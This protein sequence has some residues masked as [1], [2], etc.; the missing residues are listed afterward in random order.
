MKKSISALGAVS[1]AAILVVAMPSSAQAAFSPT[2][3]CSVTGSKGSIKVSNWSG[4]GATVNLTISVTDTKSDGHHSRIRLLSKDTFGTTKH[5]P[6]R[7]NYDG[8]NATKT[9]TTTASDSG[10]LFDLGVQVGTGE[11]SQVITSCVDA[12]W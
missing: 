10:G 12:T 1:A 3:S 4:P 2:L 9:W 6:W 7:M 11:G 5:W 8:L